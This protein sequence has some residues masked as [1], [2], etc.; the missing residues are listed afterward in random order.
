MFFQTNVQC[1]Y[2]SF[3]NKVKV[4]V[5]ENRNMSGVYTCDSDEGGCD[6]DFV[7]Y[8]TLNITAYAKAIVEGESDE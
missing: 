3:N 1:P 5:G 2:C 7:L 8:S 6:K 4:E